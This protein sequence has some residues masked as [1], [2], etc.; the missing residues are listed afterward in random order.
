MTERPINPDEAVRKGAAVVART[1]QGQAVGEGKVVAYC[2]RPTFI[3]EGADGTRFSWVANMVFPTMPAVPLVEL[4][5][6]GAIRLNDSGRI[7]YFAKVGPGEVVT[8]STPEEALAK[9]A[10]GEQFRK[11]L[12][13]T[14]QVDMPAG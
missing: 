3:I 6:T 13:D 2:D 14:G 10:K 1:A 5:D 11:L 12:S 8:G 9:R 7:M 4:P